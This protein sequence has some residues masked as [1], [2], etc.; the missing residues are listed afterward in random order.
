MTAKQKKYLQGILDGERMRISE[1]E[2]RW[3]SEMA[4]EV[5]R[6][7]L[8]YF[9]IDRAS[10]RGIWLTRAEAEALVAA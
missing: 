2:G 4:Y 1:L 3:A 8:V 9:L 7:H 6:G 5:S 10:Q